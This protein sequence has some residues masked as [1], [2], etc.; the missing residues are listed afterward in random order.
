VFNSLLSDSNEA[1]VLDPIAGIIDYALL[2]RRNKSKLI[3]NRRPQTK[4]NYL[5]ALLY[6]YSSPIK[7]LVNTKK[8]NTLNKILYEE[9]FEL[10][11]KYVVLL[12]ILLRFNNINVKQIYDKLYATMNENEYRRIL[13][14]IRQLF[15]LGLI[16]YAGDPEEEP[17]RIGNTQKLAL[18]YKLSIVGLVFVISNISLAA[19]IDYESLKQLLDNYG[20]NWIF[21]YFIYPY[22][23]KDVLLNPDA[24]TAFLNYLS[25]ACSIMKNSMFFYRSFFYPEYAATNLI[26]DQFT[27]THIFNWHTSRLQ[28]D[29]VY[30]QKIIDSLRSYL[31]KVFHWDWLQ[32]ANFSLDHKNNMIEITNGKHYSLI[33][34]SIQNLKV[35]LRYNGTSYTNIFRLLS[36]QDYVVVLGR[37]KTVKESLDS[38]FLYQ[39]EQELLLLLYDLRFASTKNKRIK[40]ILS[41]DSLYQNTIERITDHLKIKD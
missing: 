26:D 28:T 27:M 6:I 15:D 5:D 14:Q 4:I 24:T 29:P 8:S 10:D 31:L 32:A 1:S 30:E 38:S 22:F 7:E 35:T 17:I 40:Q 33:L 3:K 12:S 37:D 13:R 25:R 18:T 2:W 20:Y 11:E 21:T 39:C 41:N 19:F 34:F 9:A 36:S 16:E 23:S